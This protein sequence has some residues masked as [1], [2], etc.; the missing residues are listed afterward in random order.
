M[1]AITKETTFLRSLL[2]TIL[3]DFFTYY[4]FYVSVNDENFKNLKKYISHAATCVG[5]TFIN[6]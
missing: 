3:S 1:P 2:I 6:M 5:I 4:L